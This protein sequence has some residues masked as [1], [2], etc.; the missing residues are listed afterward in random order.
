MA[1]QKRGTTRAKRD[2]A[3]KR[4]GN[5]A[6]R[7]RV[8]A[9]SGKATFGDWIAG[10]RLRTLGMAVGTVA[11]GSGIA[12]DAQMFSLP[13]GLLCLAL[14]LCLQIGVNFANDYSDGIRGTDR[15]RVGP[16]RLTGSGKAQAKTVRNVALTFLAL[17]AAAGLAIVLMTQLWWLLAL[18][19]VAILAAWF[20]TGGK[21]PYGYMAMGELVSFIFF[22][23]VPVMG[24]FY[25]MSGG[26]FSEDAL[27]VGLAMGSFA[28][29]SMLVNNI[30]DIDS[31]RAVG[32]R[33]LA[34][35]LGMRMSRLLYALLMIL[36]FSVVALYS[37]VLMHGPWVMLAMLIALPAVVIVAL[38]NRPKD[39]IIGL[40]L[41]GITALLV[42]VGLG[43]S[44]WGGVTGLGY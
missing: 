29:A 9:A 26:I 30:R 16:S 40:S 14:A 10:A 36:P 37:I 39:F 22:G 7:N 3:N 34:T 12:A 35:L 41:S 20:Y 31:D 1:N 28:A 44:F 43:I 13:V 33:T 24:T 5:P 32:K 6:K 8:E 19:A 4:S 25:A 27:Y 42:G 23:P 17:G 15:D 18:G 2:A 11:A 21:R 38:G